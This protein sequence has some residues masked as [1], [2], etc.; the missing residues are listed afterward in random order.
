MKIEINGATQSAVEYLRDLIITG[1]LKPGQKI[2]ETALAADIGLSRPPIREALRILE[3]EKMVVTIPRKYTQVLQI[4]Q[5]DF[6]ELF[7]VRGMIECYALELMK[8]NQV[9]D[10]SPLEASINAASKAQIKRG[11]SP[12]EILACCK[13]FTDFH[14]K[15]VVLADN[16]YLKQLYSSIT[17]SLLRYQYLHFSQKPTRQLF[18]SHRDIL[19]SIKKLDYEEA[20]A[21]LLF[22]MNYNF[23][24][25]K[26]NNKLYIS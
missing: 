4:S 1:Q 18:E 12:N 9:K 8:V 3:T 17:G 7:Q 26:N 24:M 11:A 20:K 22:H 19:D 14:V 6:K 23:E 21:K 15:I 16:D 5:K 2:N 13:I 10:F 25:I